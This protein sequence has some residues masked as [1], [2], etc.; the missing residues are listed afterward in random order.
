M[1]LEAQPSLVIGLNF[2]PVGLDSLGVSDLPAFDPQQ[3][4][5]LVA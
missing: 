3:L 5:S 1:G 2:Q 4:E